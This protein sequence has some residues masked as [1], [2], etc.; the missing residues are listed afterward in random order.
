[1]IWLSTGVRILRA[2]LLALC[3]VV[4]LLVVSVQVEQRILRRRA[5]KLLVDIRSLQIHRSTLADV[6]TL[7]RRWGRFTRWDSNCNRESCGFE[8]LWDDFLLRHLTSGGRL[9]I[10]HLC[11]LAG[12]RPQQVFA[13]VLV[14]NGIATRKDF[15]VV[16]W[17]TGRLVAGT[18]VGLSPDGQRGERP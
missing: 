4:L 2:F 13:G 7:G 12:G 1:V 15:H 5:E 18:L 11:M 8:I 10:L 14:E 9:N 17:R 3:A 6:E 16:V